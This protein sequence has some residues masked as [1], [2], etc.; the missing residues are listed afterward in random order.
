MGVIPH[1]EAKRK[2]VQYGR[3]KRYRISVDT[4]HDLKVHMLRIPKC[5]RKILIGLLV[6]IRVHDLMGQ[7]A[8]EH[9]I[10][11]L[12]DKISHGHIHVF[13]SYHPHQH[14]SKI[15]QWL[16]GTSSR[17]LLQDFPISGSSQGIDPFGPVGIWR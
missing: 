15:V 4:K 13:I 16:K 1:L 3:V 7:I 8:M 9:D 5:R 17:L 10:Q 14:V 11:I 2:F 6:A 12:S